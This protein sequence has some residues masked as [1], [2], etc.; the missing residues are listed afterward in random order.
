MTEQPDRIRVWNKE[1]RKMGDPSTIQEM[2][3]TESNNGNAEGVLGMEQY[4]VDS[5]EYD[6]L[7]FMRNTG[8][9]D[10]ATNEE[11]FSDD[12][13]T[14]SI[15]PYVYRVMQKRGCWL[16]M[17]LCVDAVPARLLNDV[18]NPHIVGNVFE[19]KELVL[20]GEIDHE[21]SNMRRTRERQI[22]THR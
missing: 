10:H 8:I 12:L 9:Y 5:N 2:L 17:S 22:N 14:H 1:T 15:E 18:Y 13:I 7:V 4:P 21:D 11:I 19:K 3:R 6:H 16:A 20:K